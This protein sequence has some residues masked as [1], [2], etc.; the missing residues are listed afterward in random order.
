MLTSWT[1][2]SYLE[3]HNMIRGITGIGKGPYISIHDGFNTVASWAG[4]LPGSDR[5]ILDTHPYF[6]FSGGANTQ[7]IATGTDPDKAGGQWPPLACNA[8]GASINNRCVF[9]PLLQ[10]VRALY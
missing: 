5:I 4:F 3:A 6:A 10:L 9:V 7:P 8:W 1:R 2:R